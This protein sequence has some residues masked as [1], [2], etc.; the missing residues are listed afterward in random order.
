MLKTIVRLGLGDCSNH[1]E[2]QGN[3]ARKRRYVRHERFFSSAKKEKKASTEG[4]I[5]QPAEKVELR[6][7]R[8]VPVSASKR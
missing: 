5:D 7:E 3:P 6:L 8:F 2:Q 4:F 1:D